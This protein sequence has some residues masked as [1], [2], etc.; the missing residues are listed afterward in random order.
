MESGVMET[1]RQVAERLLILR[2]SVSRGNTPRA[3]RADDS[4]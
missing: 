4:S 3:R 1:D 2:V